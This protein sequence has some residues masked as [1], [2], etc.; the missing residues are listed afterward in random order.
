MLSTLL[1]QVRK[2]TEN[3][4]PLAH[5]AGTIA[6]VVA[7]KQPFYPLYLHAIV[8]AAAWPAW[9]TLLSTPFFLM[10][11]AIARRNSLLGR[12]VL[13]IAGVANTVL[14]VKLFGVAS[15]VELFL[16]PCV[17][18]GVIL[19][20]PRERATMVLVLTLP[21]AAY[22]VLDWNLGPPMQVFSS[23]EY[24]SIIAVHAISVAALTALVGLLFA[25]ILSERK[26]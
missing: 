5:A 13:P 22:L 17:L 3:P 10:V 15:A 7:G 6:I 21:F 18:L 9:L 25:S 11:P 20:R 16:L 12:A 4:D 2:Y 24:N 23:S 8:G 19:F 1:S 26:L 14:C